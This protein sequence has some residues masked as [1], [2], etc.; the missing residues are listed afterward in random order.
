LL[1]AE[2]AARR[3]ACY[4]AFG[5]VFASQTKPLAAL[6]SLSLLEQAR[7]LRLP[8]VAIGGITL[9]TAPAVIAAGADAV[10]V[11]SDLFLADDVAEQAHRY[12]QLFA[13][14]SHDSERHSI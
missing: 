6:A 4:V 13:E 12:R 14:L 1:L 5:S 7:S 9:V 8:R 3:G 11:I 2:M 10:A